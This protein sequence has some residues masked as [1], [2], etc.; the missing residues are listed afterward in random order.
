MFKFKEKGKIDKEIKFK[1][2]QISKIEKKLKAIKVPFN[3]KI[4]E[5][6]AEIEFIE[7][8]LTMPR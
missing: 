8:E 2:D 3:E 7:N 6:R 4:A 1:R 5:L